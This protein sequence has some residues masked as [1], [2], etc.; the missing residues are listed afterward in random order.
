MLLKPRCIVKYTWNYCANIHT[1]I[2]NKNSLLFTVDETENDISKL[3]E[4][5]KQQLES[6]KLCKST[7]IY[8]KNLEKY[9]NT[10]NKKPDRLKLVPY[11]RYPYIKALH[12]NTTIYV[13]KK[14]TTNEEQNTVL[15]TEGYSIERN[16]E[17]F[18]INDLIF[19]TKEIDFVHAYN[20]L[21]RGIKDPSTNMK[22]KLIQLKEYYINRSKYIR[23]I[24][25]T[26][27]EYNIYAMADFAFRILNTNDVDKD[28]LQGLILQYYD[29]PIEYINRCTILPL[30]VQDFVKF[31]FTRYLS[32]GNS[33]NTNNIIEIIEKK[34]EKE[35]IKF[36]LESLKQ[37]DID[38]AGQ[39]EFYYDCCK[40][41][42]LLT[43]RIYEVLYESNIII[44]KDV[45][46]IYIESLIRK[47]YTVDALL[48]IL[49][50]IKNNRY[51]IEHIESALYI[52]AQTNSFRLVPSLLILQKEQYGYSTQKEV[53]NT[54]DSKILLSL[55]S[56]Y[57]RIDV[58]FSIEEMYNE[59]IKCKESD[60]MKWDSSNNIENE[61]DHEK[62]IP[63][64]YKRRLM[65]IN[66][67]V[68][69]KKNDINILKTLLYNDPEFKEFL[70]QNPELSQGMKQKN[71]LIPDIPVSTVELLQ[72][73][74]AMT[75]FTQAIK[76]LEKSNIKKIFSDE[77]IIS[78]MIS[79]DS[80]SESSNEES[81]ESI[82]NG[83]INSNERE[84]IINLEQENDPCIVSSALSYTIYEFSDIMR[85][86]PLLVPDC[87]LKII[88]PKDIDVQEYTNL[89]QQVRQD[90]LE[91]DEYLQK[92]LLSFEND[93][94]SS[95][96]SQNIPSKNT[97]LN[98]IQRRIVELSKYDPY[99]RSMIRK[100]D[101][102]PPHYTLWRTLNVTI[103]YM[104]IGRK[105]IVLRD[106]SIYIS[107]K[108]L[109]R[110]INIFLK[111]GG[112]I[113]MDDMFP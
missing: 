1:N 2:I 53:L 45:E 75:C 42:D 38:M 82:A 67:N 18:N 95:Y 92:Q 68:N 43:L 84:Y 113:D 34:K 40:D 96:N 78:F 24:K 65:E 8:N 88:L 51:E 25:D 77:P 59:Y 111:K 12:K 91:K 3:K 23:Q 14:N 15:D 33:D 107:S 105:D 73:S 17:I 22:K 64:V 30:Y 47:G 63:H 37:L 9:I 109:T 81:N 72:G 44:N 13:K 69:N 39:R 97:L 61:V 26:K 90:I 100:N 60:T 99:V 20:T 10:L 102:I 29:I 93:I 106:T 16:T 79:K 74:N 21:I 112:S 62:N 80:I 103:L 49:H 5:E 85:K 4:E 55:V 35:N 32:N 50:N 98:R 83:G 71:A 7:E 58:T 52:S 19:L 66:S 76:K 41:F 101:Q 46:K 48:H 108:R 28:V 87:T 54:F 27:I 31:W 6:P 94:T 110:A 86:N 89:T 11:G 57:H 36:H 70:Q 56:S 104:I